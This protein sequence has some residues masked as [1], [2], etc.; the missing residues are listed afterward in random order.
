MAGTAMADIPAEYPRGVTMEDVWAILREHAQLAKETERELRE[1]ERIMK[2]NALEAKQGFL[3][4]KQSFRETEQ[5]FR[6]TERMQKRLGKQMGDLHNSFG[7]IAEHLV[8]PGIVKRFNELGFHFSEITR[9]GAAITNE[10]GTKVRAEIDILLQNGEYAIAIEVK[11]KPVEKDVEHHI[12][13]LK[14]LREVLNKTNDSRKILGAI[15]GA[16]FPQKVKDLTLE[17]GM[18]VIEQSG[19]TMKIDVPGGFIPKEW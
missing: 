10:E 16:I 4:L 17:A 1:T 6:E 14:I 9:K 2:E 13:R 12:N 15:A 8:A 5:R 19:D 3:E 18:Y 7:K 11:T